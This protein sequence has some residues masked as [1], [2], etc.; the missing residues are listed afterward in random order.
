[1]PASSKRCLWPL[2]TLCREWSGSIKNG[3]GC[4]PARPCLRRE[5][6]RQCGVIDPAGRVSMALACQKHFGASLT[7]FHCLSRQRGSLHD[8][9]GNAPATAADCCRARCA[10]NRRD[11]GS[12]PWRHEKTC[13]AL[14]MPFAF[15]EHDCNCHRQARCDR[16]SQPSA[17]CTLRCVTG[18]GMAAI[19][20]FAGRP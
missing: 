19:G 12:S 13:Q 17:G 9:A 11:A 1:M 18:F 5:C 6:E 3:L 16:Q 2:E 10:D 4:A 14:A 20:N 7:G 8:R 15:A